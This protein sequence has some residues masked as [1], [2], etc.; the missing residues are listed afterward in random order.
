M[1]VHTKFLLEELFAKQELAHKALTG[2][3]IAVCFQPHCTL[4]FPAPG[5]NHLFDSF[6]DFRCFF[7]E[8]GIELCLRRHKFVLRVALH[9]PQNR[10]K[11]ALNLFSRL[12]QRPKPR[13]I[14]M[15]VTNADD[16]SILIAAILPIKMFFQICSCGADSIDKSITIRFAAIHPIDSFI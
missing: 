11:R 15:R 12:R 13:N 3:Q 5:D 14:N 8:V 16:A 2:W 1:T 9:Q 6:I 4:N 10:R 7:F